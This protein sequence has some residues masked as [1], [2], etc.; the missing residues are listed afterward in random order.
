M[1]FEPIDPFS[2]SDLNEDLE[3]EL[4]RG[5]GN[6]RIMPFA[7]DGNEGVYLHQ[8]MVFDENIDIY[9]SH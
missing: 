4:G 7:E 8:I 9:T 5:L 2:I 6:T 1:E 3:I